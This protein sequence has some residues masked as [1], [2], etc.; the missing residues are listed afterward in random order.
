MNKSHRVIWSRVRNCFVVAS[1]KT[2]TRGKPSTT[3]TAIAA[4]VAA[5]FLAPGMASAFPCAG[6][7]PVDTA[8]TSGQ[9]YSDQNVTISSSGSVVVN[10]PGSSR[11]VYVSANPYTGTFIN[12][13]TI[14]VGAP[15]SQT[16]R[17]GVYFGNGIGAAGKIVNSGTISAASPSGASNTTQYNY[18]IYVGNEL[19][20]TLTNSGTIS[21]NTVVLNSDAY[22]YGVYV[23]GVLSGAINNSGNIHATAMSATYAYANG[24]YVGSDLTGKL[25]NSGTIRATAASSGNA[26]AYGVIVNGDLAGTLENTASGTIRAEANAAS[27]A[28]AYG[29]A[30]WGSLT[31]TLSNAGKIEAVANGSGGS[32]YGVYNYGIASTGKLINSGSI[33]ATATGT[34]SSDYAYGVHVGGDLAGTLENTATGTISATAEAPNNDAYA[35]GVLVNSD[36][37]GVITNSGTISAN[38]SSAYYAYAYGVYVGGS[39]TGTLTNS[40]TIRATANASAS[41]SDAYAYGIYVGSNLSGTLTNTGSI[42]A[43]ARSLNSDAYAAI[44]VYVSQDLSLGG[45]LNNSGTITATAVAASYASPAIGVYIGN[46]LAGTLVNSG[47]ITATATATRSGNAYAYGVYV[48]GNLTGAL[49]NTGTISATAN[50]VSSGGG[51]RAAGV[52]VSGNLDGTLSNSGIIRATGLGYVTDSDVYSIYA[53]GGTGTINNLAGGLLDGQVYAGGSVNVNNAGT[54]DTRLNGSYVG[55]N[56]N[57]GA[58]GVLKIGAVDSSTYGSLTVGGTATLAA[59]TGIRVTASPVHTLAAAD[60]L[61]NVISAGTLSMSTIKV[62]DNI[63]ALNFTAADNLANGVNL[64]AV[65]SGMTSVAAVVSGAG[66]SSSGAASVLDGLMLNIDN[67][68]KQIADMLYVIGGATTAQGVN[69][70]VAQVLPLLSGGTTQASLNAMHGVNGVVAARQEGNQGRSSGETFYGDKKFWA[71]PFGSW[72]NQDDRN[73]VSGYGATTYGL[74]LGADAE[75]ADTSRVGLAFAYSRSD[76]DG[77]SSAAPQGSRVHSYQIVGYGSERLNATDELTYQGDFG[78]HNNRGH[79]N[80]PALGL[81]ALSGYDSNSVHVGAGYFTTRKLSDTSRFTPSV[82]VD[83]TAMWNDAYTETGAGGLNLVVG[84]NNTDELIVSADAK[85]ARDLSDNSI[86]TANLGAGYDLINKRTSITSAFAGAP[87]AGFSTPGID[88]SPWMLR[89]GLGYVSKTANE[90]EI[91]ARYDVEVRRGFDNQTVSVKARWAF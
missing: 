73:G 81:V 55:G 24:V 66:G 42:S 29:I 23:D 8:L 86:F 36:L 88:P 76:V 64:T 89:G 37:S 44:G 62:Q 56:Y 26:Q 16:S 3:R 4:A 43:T 85:Y 22:A 71:K 78:I 34:S 33:S 90:V 14:S 27:W 84:K 69:D 38:A 20:G 52:E 1:E 60:V 25:T 83:Y 45:V 41:G 87:M 63:M 39:L 48:G 31:G 9:C 68:N 67:Q 74:V 82:K 15:S 79:R 59:G 70:A 50:A 13:G 72:A 11:A 18:G 28:T 35:Y 32:A 10:G 2:K 53:N 19:A 91:T 12:N 80:I 7:T 58:T 17:Y 61:A 46:E 47:T 5:L 65:A 40:G 6:P 51:Y 75:I 54:I 77:N 57:Q 30:N 21:A 49:T